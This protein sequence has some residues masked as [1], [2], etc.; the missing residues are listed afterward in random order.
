MFEAVKKIFKSKNIPKEI[1]DMDAS[2]P[3]NPESF[4]KENT[5]APRELTGKSDSKFIVEIERLK[6][7]LQAM[8]E[9]KKADSE[10]F[11]VISE[12]IGEMRSME[13][14]KE[15][16]IG[17]LEVKATRAADLVQSVQPEKLM[18]D[19]LKFEAKLEGLKGKIESNRAMSESVLEQLKEVKRTVV[20]FEDTKQ[21]LELNKDVKNEL[22]NMQRISGIVENRASKIESIFMDVERKFA[23]FE[24]Y[25]SLGDELRKN[26]SNL[27]TEFNDIKVKINNLA[28][29]EDLKK[30]NE[31]L[32]KELLEK[33]KLNGNLQEIYKFLEAVKSGYDIAKEKYEQ[34]TLI[35]D[36]LISLRD[37]FSRLEMKNKSDT[38]IETEMMKEIALMKELVERKKG[39]EE[40]IIEIKKEVN[41]LKNNQKVNVEEHKENIDVLK[42]EVNTLK[43][44]N[45]EDHL[46]NLKDYIRNTT[47]N[48]FNRNE[49][50]KELLK[51]GWN[52]EEVDNAFVSLAN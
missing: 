50:T 5:N 40:E 32:G 34:V 42:K 45:E 48:G 33:E 6:A 24:K 4:E 38:E 23:E 25:Q 11:S 39:N 51:K 52:R 30:T 1:G 17:R 37:D 29:K 7:R 27:N 14:E 31:V 20:M 43:V 35:N 13:F 2:N 22:L 26:L 3:E 8:E 47:K 41:Y 21:I 46:S 10:R 16:Q 15:K 36:E 19:V 9:M 28:G 44:K 18:E 49:I 12:Q